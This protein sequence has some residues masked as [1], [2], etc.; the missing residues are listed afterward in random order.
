MQ[1]KTH[2]KLTA[3][4]K[5]KKERFKDNN[6]ASL[7][8]TK[9]SRSKIKPLPNIFK[10]NRVL[11]AIDYFMSF[12]LQK[13]YQ[14]L[15]VALKIC[16]HKAT[17]F[18]ILFRKKR[19]LRFLCTKKQSKRQM[20]LSMS[21]EMNKTSHS[22]QSSRNLLLRECGQDDFKRWDQLCSL[23]DAGS[24]KKL[25]EGAYGEVFKCR[26]NSDNKEV[27][28][29]VIPVEA[30]FK[31]NSCDTK[32]Y[33]QM[34]NEVIISK[35]LSGLRDNNNDKENACGDLPNMKYQ[36]PYTNSF[37]KLYRVHCVEGKYP[38]Y[39]LNAWILYDELKSSL[40]DHP[41]SF[42][43]N[44]QYVVFECELGGQDLEQFQFAN[45]VQ[46]WSLLHQVVSGMAVAEKQ[47][48][49]EHRDLH[50]GNILVC[51]Q[52]HQSQVSY[53]HEDS[54][55]V[56]SKESLCCK[57]NVRAII[58]DFTL[59]HVRINNKTYYQNLELDEELFEG[60]SNED[61]QFEVYKQMRQVLNRKWNNHDPCTNVLWVRYLVN[62][63]LSKQYSRKSSKQHVKFMNKLKNLR[64]CEV[65]FKSC[66]DI[67]KQIEKISMK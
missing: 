20:Y 61:E 15:S 39:L 38:P 7:I 64:K 1:K 41:L 22:K 51:K 54:C 59:S 4:L 3:F 62:K 33:S 67:L 10:E 43:D 46:A 37:A 11:K 16:T 14:Y 18:S 12:L 27:V 66:S 8:E 45:A 17:S 19:F 2:F 35:S 48:D 44:L 52:P 6:K 31:I 57:S 29:K 53:L 34:L 60:D 9:K 28:L 30:N 56:A 55:G 25:G 40:N 63:L 13:L 24:Y 50:W 32:T 5:V 65:E 47:L 36:A 26:R 49:F 58:I 42:P 23:F 21:D